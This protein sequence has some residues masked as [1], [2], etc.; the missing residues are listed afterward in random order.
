MAEKINWVKLAEFADALS[1]LSADPDHSD[2]LFTDAE[3]K[4][5][6]EG[7]RNLASGYR[8][9]AR[10]PCCGSRFGHYPGCIENA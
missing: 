5:M 9:W 7:L 3:R 8:D 2:G 10:K 4:I 6:Q 1:K